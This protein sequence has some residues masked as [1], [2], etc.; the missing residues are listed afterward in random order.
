MK[1][2]FNIALIA[3]L[4]VSCNNFDNENITPDNATTGDEI[5]FYASEDTKTTYFEGA[6]N[7]GIHWEEFVEGDTSTSEDD[8]GDKISIRLV[9][10]DH[11]LDLRRR[12]NYT[13]DNTGAST[14]FSPIANT[15]T[16]SEM[17]WLDGV[18]NCIM[19]YYPATNNVNHTAVDIYLPTNQTQVAAND[20]SHIRDLMVMKTSK[21]TFK[22]NEAKP[23]S[24]GLE[25]YNLYSIV[26]LTIK[27]NATE[28]VVTKVEMS[29]AATPLAISGKFSA[30]FFTTKEEDAN[31]LKTKA[32]D[33]PTGVN[34]ITTTLSTPAELTSEGIKVY[35]VTLPGY[36][37]A[38]DI[39]IT[40]FFNDDTVA[41]CNM[42]AID[43]KMNSVYRPTI[44]LDNFNS[45]IILNFDF[46][47][48]DQGFGAQQ[49]S[50]NNVNN[51][52]YEG[53]KIYKFADGS[54]YELI[55]SRTAITE[56]STDG[57]NTPLNGGG[58]ALHR[59]N[60]LV[61]FVRYSGAESIGLPA[62]EGYK[63]TNVSGT[64]LSGNVPIIG[65][66]SVPAPQTPNYVSNPTS[67]EIGKEETSWSLDLENSE[68]NT[69]Y[70]F[71][72]DAN[73]GKN[74]LKLTGLTLT[75]EEAK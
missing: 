38:G 46:T 41:E 22:A 34:N 19:A 27:S 63:L 9:D 64:R 23:S 14:T 72:V 70:Y 55:F 15:W 66:S 62:I 57:K 4:L 20:H 18:D 53:S 16:N 73:N 10:A 11:T 30:N 24:V 33:A 71:Y 60:C 1:R 17:K 68:A 52:A 69:T 56:R 29:S 51:N 48:T 65:I 37:N 74:D 47:N 25:F 8:K 2:I 3:A 28:K 12:K 40:T 45:S 61:M 58:S 50:F 5:Q 32:G 42:G 67:I 21:Q 7:L 75:Y 59:E 26:E 39:T 35:F 6:N 13:A 36:H 43:F 54:E 49:S 44:T 31:G